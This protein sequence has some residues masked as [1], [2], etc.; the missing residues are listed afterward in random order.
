MTQLVEK[1]YQFLMR[2]FVNERMVVLIEMDDRIYK[3]IYE[4]RKSHSTYDLILEKI[5]PHDCSMKNME[6]TVHNFKDL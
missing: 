4:S 6:E 5:L 1:E 2:V 3:E